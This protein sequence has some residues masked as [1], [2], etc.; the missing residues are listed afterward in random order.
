MPLKLLMLY[1]VDALEW[2]V[3]AIN[4]LSWKLSLLFNFRERSFDLFLGLITNR[5]K[6]WFI[7]F[8]VWQIDLTW[9]AFREIPLSWELVLK[10]LEWFSLT[11]LFLKHLIADIWRRVI[12]LMQKLAALVF[13]WCI[14]H[15]DK[16]FWFI[17]LIVDFN[18]Y[19]ILWLL[20]QHFLWSLLYLIILINLFERFILD[21]KAF[22]FQLILLGQQWL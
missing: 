16:M 13:E 17:N 15:F 1:V 20:S 12:H 8:H 19:V 14:S 18:Y 3:V 7:R 9:W 11:T 4:F 2:V 21:A 22:I 6:P 10:C 5:L